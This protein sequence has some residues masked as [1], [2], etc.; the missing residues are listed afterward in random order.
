MST[1]IDQ[2][3]I[4]SIAEGGDDFEIICLTDELIPFIMRSHKSAFAKIIDDKEALYLGYRS[5]II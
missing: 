2:M 3:A 4:G 1:I 5:H